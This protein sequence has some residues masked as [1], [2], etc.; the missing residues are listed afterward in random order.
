MKKCIKISLKIIGILL[1]LNGGYMWAEEFPEKKGIYE[2]T[3]TLANGTT[4]RYTL[5]I[6]KSVSSQQEV[7]LIMA[8]HYGG[9]VT[10]WYGKGYLTILVKPALWKLGAIIV[11]PDCPGRGW[12]NPTAEFAVIALMNHIKQ[13]YTINDKQVLLTGFSMGAIGTWYIAAR[14][15]DLFSAAIPVSGMAEQS[16]IEMFP[17]LPV[18]VI[19]S[20]ADEIFP[21]KDVEKMVQ[22]LESKGVPVK[23]VVIKRIS[24]YH[25]EDFTGPLRKAI[26]WVKQLWENK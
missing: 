8:L 21:I 22:T 9:K 3:F 1:I 5:Y 23:L 7:P 17:D 12:D 14:H 20:K 10:P 25:T 4:M 18:Y 11:A 24:H 26:P 15:P 6:P 2:K 13:H 19:H 16:T